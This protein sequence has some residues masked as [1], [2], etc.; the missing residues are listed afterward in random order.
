M[1]RRFGNAVRKF[2]Y[3]RYGSDQL[4]IVL[5]VAAIAISFTNSI[6]SLIFWNSFVYNR[7]LNPILYLLM[8]ALLG[9]GI[10]RM[11]SRNI[12]ARQKENRKFRQLW[13]CLTDRKNRY[14]RCPRCKQTV[15]VPR[16]RGK[17]NIT[18]PKCGE[19]FIKKT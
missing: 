15:R 5:L 6:L 8:L 14:F 3:G 7:V 10:F 13:S 18:C 16:K 9:L 4:N 1:F 11:L 19:R 17:I 12:Y 2:M